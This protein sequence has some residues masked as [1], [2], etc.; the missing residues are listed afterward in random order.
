MESIMRGEKRSARWEKRYFSKN[1]AVIWVDISTTLQRDAN[2]QPLYFITTVV[3]ITEK[4]QSDEKINQLNSELEKR[5]KERTAQLEEANNELQAFAYSVSHDLRAPLRAIDGFSKFVLEDYGNKLDTEGQRLLGL[6]RSNTQ[7]M[8]K[9]ITDILS[10]SRVTRS[11]HRKSR[12]DMTKMAMSMI[13]EAASPEMQEKL[14]FTVDP[15]PLTY[16]DPT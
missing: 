5:V 3:D 13:N 4:K 11:E 14:E 1:G 7:K 10:L 12:I 15:L 6:I 16:A 9:L 2:D 8:D